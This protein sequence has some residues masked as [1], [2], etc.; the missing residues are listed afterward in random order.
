MVSQLSSGMRQVMSM[1][2]RQGHNNFST[3]LTLEI[4]PNHKI[5]TGL[6]IL[7]KTN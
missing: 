6:N 1:I 5:M 4:N 3:N 7:R 2:D